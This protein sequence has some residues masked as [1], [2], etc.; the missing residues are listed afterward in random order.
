MVVL[1]W[2]HLTGRVAEKEQSLDKLLD[3]CRGLGE[4]PG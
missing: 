4:V 2:M 3:A 1:S